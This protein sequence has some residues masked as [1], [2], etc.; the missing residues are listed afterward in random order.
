MSASCSGVQMSM[1]SSDS[2]SLTPGW[3]ALFA[4][5]LLDDWWGSACLGF[6]LIH[7]FALCCALSSSL[8]GYLFNDESS[9][10]LSATGL[11]LPTLP[12]LCF[13]FLDSS[14]SS[15]S[16]NS[17]G[18]C[19]WKVS[20]SFWCFLLDLFPLSLLWWEP[21]LFSLLLLCLC[22]RLAF[23]LLLC[24][25]GSVAF[26]GLP[27]DVLETTATA[28]ETAVIFCAN[29][30][31]AS[32]T[33]LE[34]SSSDSELASPSSFSDIADAL[35]VIFSES[36]SEFH[37]VT[38]DDF[39][40]QDSL[41]GTVCFCFFDGSLLL[42]WLT[43]SLSLSH[44]DLLL[45]PSI[46]LELQCLVSWS[47]EMPFSFIFSVESLVLETLIS[48]LCSMPVLFS[49]FASWLLVRE[50]YLSKFFILFKEL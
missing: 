2:C 21:V 45:N 17:K 6:L 35:T 9:F 16:P 48:A 11:S 37:P 39:L 42:L 49:D 14:S 1:S 31:T 10:L 36:L 33:F 26:S 13:S 28:A 12:G 5:L 43:L 8:L 50:M 19:Q 30:V 7:S 3:W 47:C 38:A 4:L 15:S 32:D 34:F 23:F 18:G 46:G 24:F 25:S 29:S 27:S 41:D 22:L 44:S 40:S 20:F